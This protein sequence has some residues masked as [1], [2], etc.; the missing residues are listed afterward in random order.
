MSSYLNT[1]LREFTPARRLAKTSLC[2]G[3]A[4]ALTF[5]LSLAQAQTPATPPKAA[6]DQ[7]V[8][9]DEYV[10]AGVRGSLMQAQEIK[11]NAPQFV[12]SIVA[13][14]IGK[15]PDNTVA[16]A[17]QHV[18]GVQVSRGA[19]ETGGVLIRG[20]PNIET[21][22]NGYEVYTGTGRGVALQDIPAEMVL[23][24]DVYKTVGADQLE[25]GVS[26]AIDIRLRRPLDFKT[27]LTVAANARGMYAS[28][29]KK[30]S[31]FIS[32]VVNN[33]WKNANGDFG[34]LVDVSYA[35]RYYEDQIFD[36]W[37]HYPE[38]FDVARDSAGIGGFYGDNF[39][40][41]VIH[42]DRTRPAA[43]LA[44]Q[45]RSN[46]GFEFYTEALFTGYRNKHDNDFFIGIPSWNGTR[47]N[48]VFYPTGYLGVNIPDPILARGQPAVNP[49]ETVAR[50]VKS[51]TAQ[52]TN[53]IISK[54]AFQ[55]DTNTFQG[56]SGVKWTKDNLLLDAELSYNISTVRTRGA[57][58]DTIAANPSQIWNI[59]Y[60]DG[61]NISA[62]NSGMDFSD[63]SNI[64]ASNFFDQWSRAYSA[65]YAV[66]TDAKFSLKNEFLT[67]LKVGARYSARTVHYHQANPS[68]YFG[69]V[70]PASSVPGLG[71][72]TTNDLF[73][74]NADLNVRRW[75]SPSTDF[76]LNNTETVRQFAGH[77]AGKPPADPASTFNDEEDNL[78]IYGMADYNSV[79]GTMPVDGAFGVRFADTH[80]TLR[81]N[82]NPL[83]ATGSAIPG[84]FRQVTTNNAYWHALPTF[85]AKLHFTDKL[86]MRL[87]ANKTLTRP[88]FGDLNPAVAL[89]HS[90]PTN[91][92]G[93]GNGGNPNL[94]PIRST[95]YDL[96]LEYYFTKSSHA[97]VTVFDHELTG[98]VQSFAKLEDFGGLQYLITR[99]QNT[100]KGKLRGY[101]LT[102][103]QFLDFM[104]VDA[105]KGLG[106]QL[107]YTGITGTTEDP[108]KPGTQQDITQVAKSSYNGILIYETGKFSGRLAYTYRGKYIDSYNQPG[109]QPPTVYVQPTKTLD[110]SLSYALTRQ[111][112]I[113]FDATNILAS[114]YRDRFGPTAMFNRDVRNYDTTYAVG[115]RFR[116]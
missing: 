40:F 108:T 44:F 18:A 109:F 12:D 66:K 33:R 82:Q 68:A 27:G 76:L 56:A 29:A 95:N 58:L 47:S 89:F 102:Y 20:L 31:V 79:I 34:L 32:G 64:N 17:L 69:P 14:D 13:E 23:G 70:V 3:S 42:G 35:R 103:T 41:Q 50:F 24:V 105:L 5:G 81:G 110:F 30:N 54:Q 78:A 46:S 21:T 90:G 11:L 85:T 43:Q 6:D 22:I 16:D 84:Q 115:A 97:T 53:T 61:S 111:I 101:E 49:G 62:Q 87:S 88:F 37:V 48:V 116:Y 57:I 94:A 38:L 77:P 28:Q 73:V 36:N 25:G 96:S 112:T 8:V 107:T 75:W 91:Q 74:S 60:N 106:F 45:W 51:F 9:L 104:S 63:P 99:P 2:A 15:L 19:G 92:V 10:V 98:Y 93:S 83:D 52:G 59:T 100:G 114:K 86:L 7:A 65:Q 55:D 72:I 71:V 67:A 113:T 4:L 26:G 39:G 1:K 80:Q